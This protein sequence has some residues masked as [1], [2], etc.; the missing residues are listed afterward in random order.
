MMVTMDWA[1]KRRTLYILVFVAIGLLIVSYPIYRIATPAPTCFDQKQNGDE[2]GVDCGGSCAASCLTN[3]KPLNVVWAKAFYLSGSSYDLGAYIENPNAS[4][5]V[6]V[7]RYTF[8]VSDNGGNILLEKTGTTQIPPGSG[9]ILFNPHVAI[10]GSPDRVNVTFNQDDLTH[11]VKAVA[12]PSTVTTKNQRL[13]NTDTSPRF[14]ATLVNTD[15]ANGVG[16]LT[17]TAI[18]YDAL[19]HP[20]AISQTHVDSVPMGG[21]QDIFFTWPNRFSKH[22]GGSICTTPVDTVLVFDRSGSMDNG[23]TPPEPLTS[24]KNAADTYI[25]TADVVDKIGLV[26]FATTASNPIDQMLSLDHDAVKNSTDAIQVAKGSVQY[27][28]LG[29]ALASAANELQSIR[30]SKDAKSV[31]VALTDGVANRPLN[32]SNASDKTYAETFAAQIAASARSAGIEIY[33]IGLGK[34]I[35]ESF[36]QNQIA[37]DPAHYFKAPTAADLVGAYKTISES[38][39]KQE[40]FITDIIVTPRTAFAQ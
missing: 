19:H 26:S 3:I 9:F 27:T 21:T 30:H 31:I 10:N 25:D 20:V 12:A 36:L 23:G 34:D 6:K 29:D 37:T 17:L 1:R 40:G 13:T 39:C 32:P 35:N 24:A 18:I 14:D 15:T 8:Q 22:V 7:A 16:S 2:T 4:S 38:I 5:G 28:D 11:W 33:T